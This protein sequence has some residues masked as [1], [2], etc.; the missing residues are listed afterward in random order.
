MTFKPTL[1]SRKQRQK[2]NAMTTI[3]TPEGTTMTKDEEN[4]STAAAFNGGDK[5]SPTVNVP[6]LLVHNAA[7]VDKAPIPVMK[8]Y[9]PI[10]EEVDATLTRILTWKRPYESLA[11]VEFMAWLHKEVMSL[12]HKPTIKGKGNVIVAVP[13]KDKKAS[14]TLFSCHTDTVHDS[15]HNTGGAVQAIA[16]DANFGHIIL[17]AVDKKQGNCLGADDGAGVWLML[18]MIKANVPGTYAFHRGE[19]R[20]GIGSN[21]ILTADPQWL[22][23][24]DCAIAFDRPNDWE[25]ITHQG[26]MRCASD[27]FGEALALALNEA[28]PMLEYKTSPNGLFTDTKVYRRNIS[29]CVNIGVGYSKQHGPDEMLDYAHLCALREAC[30]KVDWD[31]LPADRDPKALDPTPS[32]SR[33]GSYSGHG[34]YGGYGGRQGSLGLDDWDINS[35]RGNKGKKKTKAPANKPKFDLDLTEVQEIEGMSHQQIVEYI[36]DDPD[37]AAWML[38]NLAAEVAALEAKLSYLKGAMQ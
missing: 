24:F 37:S 2:G 16:Y 36:D 13:R 5:P 12:G 7:A 22:D 26:G 18:E 11:E 38:I 29:E 32:Y 6:P 34:G 27:K 23:T 35:P 4:A 31:A 19:E 17:D 25:V 20:G 1:I 3:T 10:P 28:N 21:S 9:P 14:G 33:H 15:T 30:L 8:A